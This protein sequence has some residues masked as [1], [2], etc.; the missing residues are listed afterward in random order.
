MRCARGSPG[1]VRADGGRRSAA[2][3][4]GTESGSL[5]QR[6]ASRRQ[7]IGSSRFD[8]VVLH[9]E[10]RGSDVQTLVLGQ[11]LIGLAAYR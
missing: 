5:D 11:A 10:Q 7:R 2:W 9:R 6:G 4:A 3:E 1:G 8:E